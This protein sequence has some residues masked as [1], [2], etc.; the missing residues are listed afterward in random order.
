MIK[1]LYYLIDHRESRDT[2]EQRPR[3]VA[4]RR[5][6]EMGDFRIGRLKHER[7]TIPRGEDFLDWALQVRAVYVTFFQ[8]RAV[9]VTR[10]YRWVPCT[11]LFYRYVP[12]TFRLV[13]TYGT[14]YYVFVCFVHVCRHHSYNIFV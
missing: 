8:V 3:T 9:C 6:D 13:R 5:V 14:S 12:C 1:F 10:F 4:T 2:T 7:C 11:L